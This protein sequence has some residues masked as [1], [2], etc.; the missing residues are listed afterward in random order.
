M[1]TLRF[2]ASGNKLYKLAQSFQTSGNRDYLELAFEVPEDWPATVMAV[3]YRDGIDPLYTVLGPD[4]RCFVPE[5]L[6]A[7][8]GTLFVGL[9]ATSADQRVT[10]DF[11]AVRISR[12]VGD[13]GT[14]APP[15]S[16]QWW[17]SLLARVEALE[18]GGGS[19]G[20]VVIPAY[21]LAHPTDPEA[22]ADIR[23]A[24]AAVELTPGPV[25][26]EGP[27]GP[28]GYDGAQGPKGDT[29]PRGEQG[30][31][32][33]P[34]ADGAQGLP[35]ADGLQGPKGEQG[36]QGL[37]GADGADGYTP[38]KGVDYFDGLQGPKG[39]K[40]DPGSDADVTA[41]ASNATD[42]H[43]ATLTQT[44]LN[45][46]RAAV[47]GSDLGTVSA[48]RT[49]DFAAASDYAFTVAGDITL[50]LAG[51]TAGRRCSVSLYCDAIARTV[52]WAGQTIVWLGGAPTLTASKATIVVLWAD[53][54]GTVFGQAVSE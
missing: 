50:T 45:V 53:A 52:T 41:H 42:P 12:G 27:Q 13:P 40:G 49:L 33:L 29:G 21:L 19:G 30:P 28:R 34:G 15:P 51:L 5:S 3:M 44:A 8:R 24:I 23:A 18:A 39:D 9:L 6:A 10:T 14:E 31:Q 2:R 32:G 43:G 37:P 4:R 47:V 38:V 46:T 36:P 22:H 54:R 35:G 25:G 16:P 7:E 26:P 48:S 17:E 1:N 20:S 11:I